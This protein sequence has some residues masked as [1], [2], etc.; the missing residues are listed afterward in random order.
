MNTLPLATRGAPEIPLRVGSKTCEDH[1][2]VPLAASMATSRPSAVP[3]YTLPSHTATPRFTRATDALH[4][5]RPN[6]TCVS[7]VQSTLPLAASIA[8]TIDRGTLT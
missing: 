6:G 2:C 3:T 1:S 5:E 7:D 4:M 8:R